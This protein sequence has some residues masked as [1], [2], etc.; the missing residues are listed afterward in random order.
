V[1]LI[2]GAL[3]GSGATHHPERSLVPLWYGSAV[4]VGV[5]AGPTL[6][7]LS[8]RARLLAAA[9]TSMVVV[10]AAAGIRPASGRQPFA[11]RSLEVE[12]GR[13]VAA[14]PSNGRVAIDTPDY[15]FFAIMAALGDPDR[16]EP[17]RHHDPRRPEPPLDLGA[18]DTAAALR[19]R[20]VSLLVAHRAHAADAATLGR[21]RF[22]NHA[23]VVIELGEAPSLRD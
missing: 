22:R 5:V 20:G 19:R 1:F 2:A 10:A 9:V 17:L 6:R 21:E 12:V 8:T 18:P 16:T 11:R 23:F 7:R 13:A 4:F 3:R 15:G 14:L